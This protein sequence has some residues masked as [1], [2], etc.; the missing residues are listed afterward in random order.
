MNTK[1]NKKYLVCLVCLFSLFSACF[2]LSASIAE[3]N[4]E[5]QS[6]KIWDPEFQTIVEADPEQIVDLQDEAKQFVPPLDVI[7]A[8]D[9]II[10]PEVY[11]KLIDKGQN[12]DFLKSKGFQVIKED[13]TRVLI[14][15]EI[16]SYLIK[17]SLEQARPFYLDGLFKG[18][19]LKKIRYVK[20]TNLLRAIG[21]KFF[22]SRITGIDSLY[23]LPEEYLY[24]SPHSSLKEDLHHRYFAISEMIDVH[25]QMETNLIVQRMH[26]TKQREIARKTVE[27]IKRTGMVDAH[28]SNFLLERSEEKFYAID[29]EPLGLM[30][31]KSDSSINLLRFREC[32]FLGLI[33]YRDRCCLSAYNSTPMA[34]EVESAI[35]AHLEEFPEINCV[36]R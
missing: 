16:P 36:Q 11:L 33:Y 29:T 17:I 32:V 21:R 25:P 4:I 10:T 15:S 31:E 6:F 1:I 24:E 9:S 28:P 35:L 30:I 27:F 8:L 13:E 3:H 22:Q 5:S 18:E 12:S 23:S 2:V 20:H 7:A 19:T 14:H 26:E 34:Q